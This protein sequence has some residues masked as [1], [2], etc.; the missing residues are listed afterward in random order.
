MHLYWMRIFS[1]FP[2]P[3]CGQCRPPDPDPVHLPRQLQAALLEDPGPPGVGKVLH[4][5]LHPDQFL[6][7]VQYLRQVLLQNPHP[8]HK[9]QVSLLEDPGPSGVGKGLVR[10]LY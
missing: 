10:I 9:I 8:L 7:R 5:V 2:C 4:L 6:P 3:A 1:C